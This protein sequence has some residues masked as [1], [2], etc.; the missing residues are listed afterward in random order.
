M[1]LCS[2][3]YINRRIRDTVLRERV[4]CEKGRGEWLSWFDDA[5]HRLEISRLR[6][7]TTVNPHTHISFISSLFLDIPM[8][9]RGPF[10]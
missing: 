6:F 1:F 3:R 2:I 10:I 5:V 8:F 7:I 4:T 9:G